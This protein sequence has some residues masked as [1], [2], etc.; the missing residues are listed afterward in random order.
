MS[1]ADLP[2]PGQGSRPGLRNPP[3]SAFRARNA[4]SLFRRALREVDGVLGYAGV[5][6]G[7]WVLEIGAGW[8]APAV[9]VARSRAGAR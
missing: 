7:I 8:G 6:A 9:R 4:E 1:T 5:R 3:R 2:R